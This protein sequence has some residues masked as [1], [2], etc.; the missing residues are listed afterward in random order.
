MGRK[1]KKPSSQG[2]AGWLATYGDMMTLLLCFFVM[3]FA[4]SS[5]DAAKWELVVKSFNPNAGEISQIVTDTKPTE[6]P[7]EV[8]GSTDKPEIEMD[9]DEMYY[10]LKKAVEENGLESDIELTKGEGFAFITFRNNIFFDGDSYV[11]KNEGK[12]ILDQLSTIMSKASG[13]IG[14]IE[15]LGH[16]SQARPDTENDVTADRFLASNRATVVL[17]YL[18]QKNFIDPGRLV[19]SSYGQYRPVSPF[20]TSDNRAKNRRVEILITRDDVVAR[21]LE[22]YYKEAYTS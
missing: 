2:G 10:T 18:Q 22:E 3:I 15:V 6:A 21:T 5:V 8:T 9:F 7:N 13:T 14:E 4:M 16:T 19:S 11:L 17:I 20:D 1:R 12:D